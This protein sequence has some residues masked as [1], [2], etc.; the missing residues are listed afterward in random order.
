MTRRKPDDS[1][2]KGIEAAEYPIIPATWKGTPALVVARELSEI[3]IYSCG[4]FSLIDLKDDPASSGGG[5]FTWK[6]WSAFSEQRYA[7]LK[8]SLVSPTYAQICDLVGRGPMVEAAE[9]EFREIDEK[10]QLLPRGPGRQRLEMYRDS[11]LCRFRFMLPEDFVGAIVSYALAVDTSDIKKVT[12][13]M[14]FNAAILA[15][16]GHDN[17]SDHLE[18]AFT[19][20][21]MDDINLRAWAIFND[22]RETEKRRAA[23]RG[24]RGKA[25]SEGGT[26]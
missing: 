13:D 20:F 17:P 22:W 5:P 9:K 16:R 2:L 14:L 23:K 3:Q 4:S 19:R 6:R 8:E 1:M 7:I 15:D 24:N 25:A 10:I 21:N 26:A 12:R 18:G 11:L